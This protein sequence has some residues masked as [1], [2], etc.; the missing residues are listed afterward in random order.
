MK[1][2]KG[3][4]SPPVLEFR[5]LIRS[6]IILS[7]NYV[8]GPFISTDMRDLESISTIDQTKFS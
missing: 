6:Q 3:I 4:L 1:E 5:H 2:C 8:F 7:D